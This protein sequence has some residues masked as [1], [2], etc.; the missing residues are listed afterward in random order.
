MRVALFSSMSCL[1]SSSALLRVAI[2][3][4]VSLL[5]SP[6]CDH[7]TNYWGDFSSDATV[8]IFGQ[9][10]WRISVGLRTWGGIAWSRGL[11]MHV[12]HY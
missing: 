9:A 3:L 11:R 10:V 8:D 2:A 7:S 4:L 6:L 1:Q 5:N 12:Q